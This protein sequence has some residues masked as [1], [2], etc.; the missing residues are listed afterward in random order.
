MTTMVRD[1]N[2]YPMQEV[3]LPGPHQSVTVGSTTART[4]ANFSDT[5]RA[6]RLASSTNCYIVLGDSTVEA[7]TAGIY[8]PLGSPLLLGLPSGVTRIAVIRAT[9]DGVL[10]V[11]ECG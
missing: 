4:A 8:L 3:F 11:L 9:A 5:T 6:V 2:G 7:T 1:R 10:S